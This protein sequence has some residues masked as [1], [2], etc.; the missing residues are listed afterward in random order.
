[1]EKKMIDIKILRKSPEVIMEMLKKRNMDFSL[2]KIIELDK[3]MRNI[4]AE[5]DKLRGELNSASKRIGIMKA[6]GEN[7]EE[8]LAAL[9]GLSDRVSQL[10]DE[11]R[12]VEEELTEN[13]LR[14]PNIPHS[15]VPVGKGAED[16]VEVKR[17]GNPPEF[18]FEPLPHWE[19]GKRLGILDFER[20]AKI[21]GSGFTLYTGLGA[22]LEF[23]L[24]SFMLDLHIKEHGYKEVLTPFMVNEK[25]MVTT[26]QLPKFKEDMYKIEGDDM[27][28]IPTAEVP[29]TNIHRDEI[30]PESV[31]PLK[32]VAYSPCFRLEA[33]SY[34]QDVRGIIRQHQFN[35]V[36]L[37]KFSHPDT[38]YEELESLLLDAEDVLKKLGLHYRVVVLCTGD[39]GFSASKTYDIEVWLPSQRTYK[40]ISSVSNFEDFQARRGNIRFRDSSGRV[41]YVHTLN[42]SGLA[43]GRTVAAILENYQRKDGSVRIPDVLVPYMH[44]IKEIKG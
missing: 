20:G 15:S 34:G 23:A 37:V 17:W 26:G 28:L 11:F 7:V 22:R 9:K 14:L 27:Y 33:G 5:L 16:N 4:K 10:E 35:K 3:R 12:R 32:Y 39:L 24:I 29:V 1:L 36:E 44:G 13:L 30:L 31:L 19:I 2:E 43:V 42:G 21:A 38:S 25:S 6:K 41:R 8:E 40:E 18:D